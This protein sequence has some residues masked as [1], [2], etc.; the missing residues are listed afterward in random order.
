MPEPRRREIRRWRERR[1]HRTRRVRLVGTVG[2]LVVA[3]GLLLTAAPGAY[4]PTQTVTLA[5]TS[6][7]L[8]GR[9]GDI[10]SRG[11]ERPLATDPATSSATPETTAPP[12]PEAPPPDAP[13]PEAAP[14][15]APP[16][17]A[18]APAPRPQP[19]AQ[20][21]APEVA[22][23]AA[24]PSDPG[25]AQSA[26]IVALTN[27]ERAA[28]GLPALAVS[29]CATDQA[30]ARGSLLVAEG[31]FEHDPLGPILE[32]CASRTVGENLSLGYSG[33]QAAVTG[34]MNSQG[35]RENILR[36]SFSQIG[37]GCVSGQR[38]WLCVQV[39]LG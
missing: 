33:A 35:H 5:L 27:A 24:E 22:P 12:A 26:E 6:G 28:A 8:V 20:A 32:A 21:A 18:A 29:A 14:S 11:G 7:D 38:G 17:G 3:M 36:G 13:A 23:A 37:V 1:A 39:F 16:S 15:T 34:W 9:M 31:R 10:A 19:P 25:A 2:V 30:V 4:A